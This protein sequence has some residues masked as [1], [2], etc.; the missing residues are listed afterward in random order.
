MTRFAVLVLVALFSPAINAFFLNFPGFPGACNCA[1]APPAC[2]PAPVCAPPPPQPCPVPPPCTVVSNNFPPP[3][4]Y[5]PPP[6]PV[7]QPLPQVA[8]PRSHE[9]SSGPV[10]TSYEAAKIEHSTEVVEVDPTSVDRASASKSFQAQHSPINPL[11]A[12]SVVKREAEPSVQAECNS[13]VL[14]NIIQKNMK[15]TPAESKRIIQKVAREA[16]GGRIDVICSRQKISYIVN[17]RHYC[18]AEKSGITCFVFR[19]EA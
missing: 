8:V 11:P 2:P 5:A 3:P 7:P 17:T 9:Y 4:V 1:A 13:E 14:R 10:K 16:I 18:E 12:K 6:A 19:Q 15:A